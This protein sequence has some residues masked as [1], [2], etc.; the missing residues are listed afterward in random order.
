MSKYELAVVL[1]AA[2]DDEARSATLDRVKDY[3]EKAG[4]SITNVDDWGKK[5]LA[6][7]IQKMSEAYYYFIQFE[8]ETDAPGEIESNVRLMESVIRF[9]CIKKDED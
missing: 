5:K 2:I 9:L 8:A 3:V 6:Y 1:S 7:D 4:G